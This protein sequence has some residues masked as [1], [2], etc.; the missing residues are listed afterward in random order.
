M[1]NNSSNLEEVVQTYLDSPSLPH[2][3]LPAKS[4]D[5][6]VHVFG[7]RNRFPY[8]P[9]RKN[10]PAEA[11]KE[12]LFELHQKMGIE[13]CVIVQSITH[14]TD[15]S[16][17]EDAIDAGGGHYLGVALTE[18]DVSDNELSRL[19]GK[20]FRA[21]RFHFM[22][23]ISGG[24]QVDDVLKLTHRLAEVGIHLQVHFESELVHT[25]G[26]QLLKSSV[27][28]VIDHMGRVDAAKGLHHQDFQA[29]MKL[30]DSPHFHVKVS[31]I[32]RIDSV[33]GPENGYSMGIELA[34]ELVKRFPSQCV[35]GL[36]WPHPNHTH[37]PN[38]GIL[39]DALKTIAPSAEAIDALLVHNPEKLYRFS[40]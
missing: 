33:A 37:V 18:V 11:P 14:G 4:C 23:H 2:W 19:A 17:V 10:T 28:V 3:K 26:Q 30:L 29:L 35:W 36:D 38:D 39:I 15:N 24:H 31:G 5:S 21:V 27:P 34:T 8:S 13:R 7:P 6:H 1:T 32:D 20:G 40:K 16:V 25:V 9:N 22:R 12:K